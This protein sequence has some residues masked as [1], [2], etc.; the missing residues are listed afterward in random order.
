M[1]NYILQALDMLCVLLCVFIW[2]SGYSIHTENLH[3]IHTVKTLRVVWEHAIPHIPQIC[4]YWNLIATTNAVITMWATSRRDLGMA[5]LL[6]WDMTLLWHLMTQEGWWKKRQQKSQWFPR[7][8]LTR[9][10]FVGCVPKKLFLWVIT[11]CDGP[12]STS[13]KRQVQICNLCFDI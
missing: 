13:D 10:C 11:V 1:C 8:Y 9:S 5:K 2:S 4:Y 7:R 12:L 3:T 6:W